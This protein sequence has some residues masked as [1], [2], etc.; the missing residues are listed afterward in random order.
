MAFGICW[1]SKLTTSTSANATQPVS[2][3]L[4]EKD[5][6]NAPRDRWKAY[7]FIRSNTHFFRILSAYY[8]QLFISQ[9]SSLALLSTAGS[10]AGLPVFH[11]YEPSQL[12]YPPVIKTVYPIRAQS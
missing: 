10:S 4:L 11:A 3:L 9:P 12:N 7:F 5:I 2:W 1:G 6:A 8:S